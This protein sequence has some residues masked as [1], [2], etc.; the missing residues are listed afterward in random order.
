MTRRW[1]PRLLGLAVV[2]A[3]AAVGGTAAL[4]AALERGSFT[5]RIEAALERA[6]GRAVT[7]GKVSLRPSLSP[8]VSV[9][10]A[11]IGDV[12]DSAAPR[13]ARVG[14][15]DVAFAW[16]PLLS[17]RVEIREVTLSDTNIDLAQGLPFGLGGAAGDPRGGRA[18]RLAVETL[19]IERARITL[20]GTP[21]VLALDQAEIAIRPGGAGLAL[22]AAG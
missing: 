3:L 14:R 11:T 2:L 21:R 1:L 7:I 15:L 19:R 9:T 6:S 17:G 22:R 4:L 5:S 12:A 13:V 16:L 18:P 8:M 10:G 20:P